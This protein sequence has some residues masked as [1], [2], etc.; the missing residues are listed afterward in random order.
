MNVNSRQSGDVNVLDLSGRL[1]LGEGT[2]ILRDAVRGLVRS[3]SKKLLIN[4][5]QVPYIDSSG[6]GELVGAYTTVTSN[7]GQMKLLNLDKKARD[8]LQVT[9]LYTVFEVY[10]DEPSA[11]RSFSAKA[12]QSGD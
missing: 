7:G 8:L 4:L 2:S 12:A 5:A 10:E 9:K 11:V 3:G 6:M 1:T